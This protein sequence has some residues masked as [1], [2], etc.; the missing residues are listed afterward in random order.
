MPNRSDPLITR[1][2]ARSERLLIE[3]VGHESVIYD[4][5]TSVAHA[6]MPLAAAVFMYADGNN[7]TEEIAELAGYRLATA[8][9]TAEAA[10]A[11]SELDV[12]GLLDNSARDE[13]SADGGFSRRDALKLFAATGVGVALVSSVAA[14]AALAAYDCTQCNT[15][16]DPTNGSITPYGTTNTKYPQ[17]TSWK[18]GGAPNVSYN[19]TCTYTKSGVATQ[20]FWQ[21]VPCDQCDGYQCCQVVCAPAGA[22]SAWG[23]GTYSVGPEYYSQYSGK[24][25]T[26][27]NGSCAPHCSA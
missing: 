26:T 2:L 21:C 10:A 3:A 19:A 14:P 6:L 25:C 7:T 11:V 22:G 17:P 18:S 1:P 13:A 4:Q 15:G 24:Y 16:N 9:T 27:K 5:E 23:T 20:G 8:V 12:L